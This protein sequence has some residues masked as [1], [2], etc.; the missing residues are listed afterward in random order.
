MPWDWSPPPPPE[1]EGRIPHT[2]DLVDVNHA[3]PEEEGHIPHISDLVDVNHGVE[4]QYPWP[5]HSQGHVAMESAQ[6]HV[7]GLMRHQVGEQ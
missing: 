4:G 5:V 1:E 6:V 2:S 7:L 3:P